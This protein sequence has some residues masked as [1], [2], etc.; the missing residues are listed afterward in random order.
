MPLRLRLFFSTLIIALLLIPA[1]ALY[2]ELSIRSDIWWTPPLMA[3]SLSDV[4]ADLNVTRMSSGFAD[5]VLTHP[6]LGFHLL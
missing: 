3:P 4:N 5:L 6:C 2:R 1:T